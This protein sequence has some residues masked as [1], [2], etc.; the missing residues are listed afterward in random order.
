[1]RRTISQV[2]LGVVLVGLLVGGF[3]TVRAYQKPLGPAMSLDKA[4]AAPTATAAPA[5][6]GKS[7]SLSG[8]MT[9]LVIGRDD[10]VW[11]P[12][13]GADAIRLVK[14][15]FGQK[16]A[17]VFTFQ[18]DLLLSTTALKGK[19]G[20]E[21][22]RLGPVYEDVLK[23]GATD[24]DA[25]NAIAQTII[26]NFGVAPEHYITLKESL[27]GPLI[28]TLGGIEVEVPTALTI[29]NVKIAAGKQVMNGATAMLY[30][31]DL[32]ATPT[33][34]TRVDRQNAVLQ[35][36]M[37]KATDPAV[38][39]K[40]PDLYAKFK[41]AVVTDLT[42]EQLTGFACVA[43][44]SSAASVTQ[45]ILPKTAITIQADSSMLIN[46]PVAAKKTVQDYL[47]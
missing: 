13:A 36:L 39:T 5:D 33:E 8:S 17:K 4:L 23:K 28:D 40:V 41:E 12:P 29:E 31:R 1:M 30:M 37:K 47:Q 24:I 11:E 2:L 18:R 19:Y 16:T 15:D 3:A 42:P 22:N 9:V 45:S 7:C 44:Q 21:K 6:A 26:E 46:D 32:P 34:W 25:T 27:V 14:V 43:S 20:F 38:I 10:N 35:G